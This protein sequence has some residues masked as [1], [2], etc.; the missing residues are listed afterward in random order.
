MSHQVRLPLV[1]AALGGYAPTF[2][3][4]A[5]QR[6]A[7]RHA[8]GRT[9]ET[10]RRARADGVLIVGFALVAIMMV[11]VVVDASPRRTCAAGLDSLADGAALAAADGVQEPQVYTQGLG[12]TAALD[13]VAARQQVADY[14]WEVGAHGAYRELRWTVT[15]RPTRSRCMSR[16]RWSFP[17][18]RPAGQDVPR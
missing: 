1:P 10:A 5:E 7:L 17:S 16:H 2:R 12:E 13:P 11:G 4:E 6:G 18:P 15:A 14:L 9:G 3:V 8:S